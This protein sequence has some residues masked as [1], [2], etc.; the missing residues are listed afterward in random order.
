MFDA[1]RARELIRFAVIAH[2]QEHRHHL[3]HERTW[4]E[5]HLATVMAM[6]ERFPELRIR[7]E[8]RDQQ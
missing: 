5:R 3:P 4:I 2:L 1:G 7:V 8:G 6:K